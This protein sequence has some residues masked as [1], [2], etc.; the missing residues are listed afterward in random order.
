[1]SIQIATGSPQRP[2]RM[3]DDSELPDVNLRT[4]TAQQ[5]RHNEVILQAALGGFE[6]SQK[7][8]VQQN[9]QLLDR[10]ERLEAER[11]EWIKAAEELTTQKHIRDVASRELALKEKNSERL[12]GQIKLLA[13][14]VLNRIAGKQIVP[15]ADPEVAMFGAFIESLEAPQMHAI[16]A[17]LSPEQRFVVFELLEKRKAAEEAKKAAAGT[18]N[19]AAPNGV[20]G[21]ATS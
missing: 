7:S 13:P 14:G 1:M 16:M 20:A 21:G 10:V 6:R 17:T 2:Q 4:I 5:F 3:L 19:G 15:Q 11:A 18:A 12:F 9:A 8:L